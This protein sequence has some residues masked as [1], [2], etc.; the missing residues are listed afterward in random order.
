[1]SKLIEIRIDDLTI[2]YKS[3]TGN[4]NI[5][6]NIENIDLV[7]IRTDSA[8][9]IKLDNNVIYPENNS[10]LNNNYTFD[11]LIERNN[12]PEAGTYTIAFTK[13]KYQYY[14][15]KFTVTRYAS[16]T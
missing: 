1:M 11:I 5:F 2:P 14:S 7:E 4:L 8:I 6:L 12:F 15:T 3:P 16:W 9:K 13:D 10:S